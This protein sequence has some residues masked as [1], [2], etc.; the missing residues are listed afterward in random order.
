MGKKQKR[1]EGAQAREARH[2]KHSHS[3][4]PVPG[5]LL[6]ALHTLTPVMPVAP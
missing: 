4:C 5:V 2:S 3:P 1:G 6:G